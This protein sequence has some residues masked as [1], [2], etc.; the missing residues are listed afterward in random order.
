[1]YLLSFKVFAVWSKLKCFTYLKIISFNI[2]FI[3]NLENIYLILVYN[4][5]GLQKWILE[6]MENECMGKY[7]IL[8]A[9]K[10][11]NGS[12]TIEAS[13]IKCKMSKYRI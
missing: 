8:S 4:Q 3:D 13:T 12:K 1:M 5:A 6:N 2:S 9:L 11:V 7:I 10:A